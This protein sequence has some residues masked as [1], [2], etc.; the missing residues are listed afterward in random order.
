MIFK[1]HF[2]VVKRKRNAIKIIVLHET[3]CNYR[4]NNMFPNGL[5]FQ[6]TSDKDGRIFHSKLIR[7]VLHIDKI[8]RFRMI[9]EIS[10]SNSP[11]GRGTATGR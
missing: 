4:G 3:L 11:V 2:S 5:R 1:L 7:C 9:Y 8:A 6:E 10:A